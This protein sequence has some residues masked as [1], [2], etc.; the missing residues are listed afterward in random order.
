MLFAQAPTAYRSILLLSFLILI[1]LEIGV[2]FV[3]TMGQKNVFRIVFNIGLLSVTML[4]YGS[5]VILHEGL[6]HYPV[7]REK[8]NFDVLYYGSFIVAAFVYLVIEWVLEIRRYHQRLNRNSIKEA[9]DHLP[10]GICFFNE[11]GQVILSNHT[12]NG[13]CS[14]LSGIRIRNLEELTKGLHSPQGN[15]KCIDKELKVYLFEDQRAWRF[16]ETYIQDQWGNRYNQFIATDITTLHLAKEEL[17]KESEKLK[18]TAKRI[19]DMTKNINELTKSEE[20]LNLKIRVHNY[21]GKSLIAT[22]RMFYEQDFVS[23]Q[24]IVKYWKEAVNLLNNIN[25][26]PI[27]TDELTNL[28]EAAKGIGIRIKLSGILPADKKV[29]Y[30]IVSALR[31]CTTNIARHTDGNELYGKIKISENQVRTII[32]NNGCAPKREIVEGGGLSSLRKRI[33]KAGGI[34]ALQSMPEFQLII[35]LPLGKEEIL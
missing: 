30:L 16:R 6:N 8:L 9:F 17:E 21:L 10:L 26:N 12:M 25:E 33:E 20:I 32:K 19:N 5:M 13:I 31:E 4:A 11:M 14:K 22:K 7:F 27:V 34:M 23:N 18:E 35:T 3:N 24:D 29:S 28:K 15:I 1:L 2:I